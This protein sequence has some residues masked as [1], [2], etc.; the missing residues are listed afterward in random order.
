MRFLI[1]SLIVLLSSTAFAMDPIPGEDRFES[2]LP[3]EEN[4]M[5]ANIG[6]AKLQDD[7]VFQ[8]VLRTDLNFG[9]IG[10][11]LQVPLNI[12]LYNQVTGDF[13]PTDED[14]YGLIRHE[15][16]DEPGE[17]LRAVR[18]ARFGHKREPLFLRVGDLAAELGHGTIL[19]HYMNNL[20]INTHRTGV[21]ADLNTDYGGVET[22]IGDV[23]SMGLP[24]PDS[25]LL[26]IR[27]Y[28]KPVAWSRG[29]D[30]IFNRVAVGASLVT[31]LN[32]PRHI[33]EDALSGEYLLDDDGNYEIEH[34]AAF[35]VMG[36][37]LEVDAFHS[38]ILDIVPYTDLNLV[39][40]GGWGLHNGVRATA[41]FPI[42]I[43][44][45]MPV[46]LEH[47]YFK[48]NYRPGMFSTFYEIDRYLYSEDGSTPT[49]KARY[50]RELDDGDGLNGIY[51]D[52]AL[53]FMQLIQVGAIYEDYIGGLPNIAGYVSV[54]A[55][56]II[57]FKAYYAR[58]GVDGLDDVFTLDERSY[59]VAEGRYELYPYIY[60]IGRWTRRWA[61]DQGSK[62][63]EPSDSW[64]FGVETGFTF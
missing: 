61:L 7:F 52:L 59:L 33:Q 54:P 36:V 14:Y 29:P 42:I 5:G 31:D 49:P 3:N 62:E 18:Y 56:E 2:L 23:P 53:D 58:Q 48:N 40:G 34:A 32:A 45:S 37:D 55:L 39:W 43:E 11:G 21:Q 1:V 24:T 30:S 6:F 63:F 13:G 46:R 26:G 27:L 20:D 47:R 25:K 57:Q 60:L 44:L 41:K 9:K 8:L 4:T 38:P 16:W 15:D 12:R 10:L 64:N 51:A 35:T 17:W 50:I 19:S 22:L 28:S